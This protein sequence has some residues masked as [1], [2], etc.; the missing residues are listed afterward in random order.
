[1]M[2]AAYAAMSF[3]AM[4]LPPVVIRDLVWGGILALDALDVPHGGFAWL[5]DPAARLAA[6]R[7]FNAVAIV[8]GILLTVIGYLQARRP[9]RT[10]CMN[11]PFP[12]LHPDLE[13]FRIVLIADLHAGTS[14][15]R[16]R[17]E[18]IARLARGLKPDLVAVAGDLADGHVRD[19]LPNLA[20]LR[21]LQAPLGTFFVTG[22]HDYYWDPAG[23]IKGARSLGMTPLENEARVLRRG[24]A[25]LVVG[26]VPD[27]TGADFGSAP[28]PSPA[29][30]FRGTP[31]RAF[32]LLLAHQPELAD[33]GARAGADLIVSGHTHGG[34]LMPWALIARRVHR[35]VAGL[36]RIGHTW[37]FVTTG[38][39]YW[40]APNRLG[41]PTEIAC[42]VLTRTER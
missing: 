21:R 40:G 34:Q 15:R 30:A 28:R 13:G 24:R 10:L 16:G 29:A 38:V 36:C 22:N 5:A 2:P 18:S 6:A 42:L 20:P 25:R 19:V 31:R 17:I 37:L 4:L 8:A 27:P 11:V 33:A 26:G 9:P 41:V 32:R 1:M 35:C 14:I 3:A 23:W 12:G 39:N 7:G